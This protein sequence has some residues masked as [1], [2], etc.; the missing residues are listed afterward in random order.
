[1]GY[2]IVNGSIVGIEVVANPPIDGNEENLTS[3][4]IDDIKYKVGD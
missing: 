1:M 4:E 2:I 3:I